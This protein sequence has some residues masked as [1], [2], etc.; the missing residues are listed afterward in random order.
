ML[1][2]LVFSVV[3][4][5][6]QLFKV[7][8]QEVVPHEC[9]IADQVSDFKLQQLSCSFLLVEQVERVHL[10]KHLVLNDVAPDDFDGVGPFSADSSQQE[11]VYRV[12]VGKDLSLQDVGRHIVDR[13]LLGKWEKRGV[14]GFNHLY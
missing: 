4:V 13:G 11:E 2:F 8:V 6:H 10:H 9:G 3:Q 1:A 7:H 12:E 14:K 5:L